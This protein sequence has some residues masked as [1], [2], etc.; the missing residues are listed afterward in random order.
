[1]DGNPQPDGVARSGHAI[2]S[3]HQGAVWKEK[4]A[5]KLEKDAA[6]QKWRVPCFLVELHVIIVLLIIF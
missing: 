3:V 2:G 1:V 5:K 6:L 4:T